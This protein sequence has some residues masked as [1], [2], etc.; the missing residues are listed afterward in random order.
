MELVEFKCVQRFP[1]GITSRWVVTDHPLFEQT[2]GLFKPEA[3]MSDSETTAF[4]RHHTIKSHRRTA[5][6]SRR[7]DVIPISAAVWHTSV[8]WSLNSSSWFAL[9]EWNVSRY[10]QINLKSHSSS[11]SI[12]QNHCQTKIT[13]VWI[14]RMKNQRWQMKAFRLVVV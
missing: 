12:K 8:H 14:C 4:L 3:G 9:P 13:P 2:L 1:F 6:F 7:W 5:L 11:H 10:S